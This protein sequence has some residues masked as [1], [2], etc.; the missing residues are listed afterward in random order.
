MKE[1]YINEEA[2]ERAR[3]KEDK[4]IEKFG[5]WLMWFVLGI[6]AGYALIWIQRG[7]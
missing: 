1:V 7:E 5:W 6:I 4:T 3:S 2:M